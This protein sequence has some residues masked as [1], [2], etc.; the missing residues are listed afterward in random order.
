MILAVSR[1]LT[2]LLFSTMAFMLLT[3]IS[4]MFSTVLDASVSAFCTA[5]SQLTSD[6]AMTS[7]T[8]AMDDIEISRLVG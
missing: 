4:L 6:S 8:F 1:Y 2:T 7:M 5:S 3:Q